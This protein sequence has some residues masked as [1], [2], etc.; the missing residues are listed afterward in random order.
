MADSWTTVAATDVRA[1]DRIRLNTGVE[2]LVS[3][4][5]PRFLGRN[6]LIAFI[7]DTPA[8]WYKQ[9][10]PETAEVQVADAQAE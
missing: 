3:R 1:G 6:G 5:E 10:L 2:M 7:E 9:P 4:I 8:R